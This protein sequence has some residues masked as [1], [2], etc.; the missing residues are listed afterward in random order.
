MGKNVLK[1]LSVFNTSINLLPWFTHTCM[2]IIIIIF[3]ITII[4]TI[5]STSNIC[6]KGQFFILLSFW[7]WFIS[8]AVWCIFSNVL[9]FYT[10]ESSLSENTQFRSK[11][12]FDLLSLQIN[13]Y[14]CTNVGVNLW[15]SWIYLMCS[16]DA[17]TM[18]STILW[19]QMNW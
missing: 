11:K 19:W 15:I 8:V 7:Y 16:T 13:K 18:V 4:T 2:F 6:D 5:S 10:L 1:W 17:T 3:L 14:P 9:E 12:R